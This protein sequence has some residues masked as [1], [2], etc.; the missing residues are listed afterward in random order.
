[1]RISR[2]GA[3]NELHPA[4]A[5]VQRLPAAIRRLGCTTAARSATRSLLVTSASAPH[6]PWRSLPRFRAQVG[7]RASARDR[8]D[9]ALMIFERRR[10]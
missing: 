4:M 2:T 8:D 1:M 9:A 10:A 6:A 3:V 7:L 5:P